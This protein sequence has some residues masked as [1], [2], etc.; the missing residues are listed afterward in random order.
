M[1][2]ALVIRNANF[3]NVKVAKVSLTIPDIELSENILTETLNSGLRIKV[4]MTW[5]EVKGFTTTY[6]PNRACLYDID[7]SNYFSVGFRTVKLNLANGIH[8]ICATAATPTST[9]SWFGTTVFA[10]N[11]TDSEFVVNLKQNSHL[12][13]GFKKSNDDNFSGAETLA[14][15]ITSLVLYKQN[16]SERFI[17]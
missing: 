6:I 17:N 11:T 15:F 4:G 10:W 2:K 5:N 9:P 14:D 12:F 7:L 8:F 16:N 1:G 3:E 13:M